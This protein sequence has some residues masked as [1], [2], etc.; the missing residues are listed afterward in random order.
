MSKYIKSIIKLG[1]RTLDRV[2]CTYNKKTLN[3]SCF[4]FVDSIDIIQPY[5]ENLVNAINTE[6]TGLI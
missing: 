6:D 1:S 4:F 5:S 3:H 2:N